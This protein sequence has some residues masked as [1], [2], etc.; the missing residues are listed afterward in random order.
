MGFGAAAFFLSRTYIVLPYILC[1][2]AASLHN[3][4]RRE[5]PEVEFALTWRHLRNIGLCAL[6]TLALIVIAMKVWL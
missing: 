3:I 1:G 2:L 6:G 4:A 5:A